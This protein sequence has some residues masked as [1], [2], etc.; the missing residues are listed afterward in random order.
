M[1]ADALTDGTLNALKFV[2]LGTV[3]G[4]ADKV[5]GTNSRRVAAGSVGV[6]DRRCCQSIG[7]SFILE[8]DVP[9]LT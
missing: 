5:E 9:T 3:F 1:N 4:T 2:L 8:P 6:V 7:K